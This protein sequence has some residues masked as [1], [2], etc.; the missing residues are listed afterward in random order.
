[1]ANG[2]SGTSRCPSD[3]VA[4]ASV[5]AAGLPG[6]RQSRAAWVAVQ[7]DG[8]VRSAGGAMSEF[9]NRLRHNLEPILASADPREKL[10]AYHDMPYALF[11]Y[12]PS[13]EFEL[14]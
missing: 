14:R 1:M 12:D 11:R 6:R 13:E 3:A 10:S 8:G 7:F 5:S 2:L 4:S 9:E